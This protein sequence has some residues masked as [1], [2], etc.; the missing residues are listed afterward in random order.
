MNKRIKSFN[1][2]NTSDRKRSNFN[3]LYIEGVLKG[4]FLKKDK[5]FEM[6]IYSTPSKR[7]IFDVYIKGIDISDPK[8]KISFKVGDSIE[9]AKDWV[10]ENNHNITFEKN[11]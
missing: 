3:Q 7:M 10:N 1:G 11:K 4:G 5:E 9:K 8:L 6:I 2:F